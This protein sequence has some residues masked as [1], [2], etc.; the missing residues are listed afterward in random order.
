[1][2]TLAK[3]GRKPGGLRAEQ[4]LPVANGSHVRGGV[5]RS[6][7]AAGPSRWRR[8]PSQ[9]SEQNRGLA[10]PA[11]P[12]LQQRVFDT[13]DGRPRNVA[14]RHTAVILGWC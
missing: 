11:G 1:M 13:R 10:P 2:S 14:Q 9:A 6:Q 5:S 3:A 8:F 7:V 4:D 12:E